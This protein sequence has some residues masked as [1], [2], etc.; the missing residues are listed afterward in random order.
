MKMLQA[1]TLNLS[2]PKLLPRNLGTTKI[3]N[4]TSE[5]TE[6]LMQKTS[7]KKF[8]KTIFVA[9]NLASIKISKL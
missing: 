4:D 1:K 3:R 2:K 9:K 7:N 5:K 6:K 8:Q